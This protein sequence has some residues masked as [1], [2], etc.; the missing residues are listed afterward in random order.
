MDGKN[1]WEQIHGLKAP[2]EVSWYRPHLERSLALIENAGVERD[3][4]IIDVGGGASTLVDDLLDRGFHDVTVNDISS[5]A[6]ARAKARLGARAD[7][8]P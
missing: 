8:E 5:A 4:G 6:V 3:A 1:H 7:A 2:D